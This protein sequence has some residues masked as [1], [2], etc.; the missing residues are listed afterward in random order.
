MMRENTDRNA[1]LADV[2][3]TPDVSGYGFTDFDS[4]EELGRIGYD[5]TVEL[6]DEISRFALDEAEW[7]AYLRA[8]ADRR[9]PFESTPEYFE[10]SGATAVDEP[11]VE[12]ALEHHLGAPLDPDALDFDLTNITGWGRYNVAGYE[13]RKQN[14][15]EGLGVDLHEKTH[16]PPFLRPVLDL[17]GSEF[18]ELFLT[19][20]GRL[21][22][23]DVTGSNSELRID[24][25][26]GQTTRAFAE[27]FARLGNRGL[28]AAP[29]GI[30]S[31]E[32]WYVYDEG[33]TVA[34]YAFDR[35][36]GG[37]DIGYLFG[38]RSELRFGFDVEH[39]KT[40]LKVGDPRLPALEGT[41]GAVT[42][43]WTF[44]G[45]DSPLIVTRGARI[46]AGARWV[47]ATP[48]VV[49]EHVGPLP[50]TDDQF[51]QAQLSTFAARPLAGRFSLFG[52][53][54]GGTSFDA[55]ASQLQRFQLGGPL[56][57]GALRS[58]ELRGS[59]FYLGRAGVLWALSEET[60]PSILGKFYLT[61]FYEVGDAFEQDSDPFWDFTFGLAGESLLGGVFVGGAVGQDGRG[62][63]FFALGRLF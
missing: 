9:R 25:T 22:L 49:G 34:E 41:A 5:A 54:S 44:D 35:V 7:E 62:G 8:R 53:A 29:R 52:S 31:Q 13:G 27:L 63:F 23:F 40:K 43:L 51:Y 56:R 11:V 36:G 20:G 58:G 16:G 15:T 55:T 19:F 42:A 39:Q 3:I 59:H 48:D 28:F 24:A 32:T 26:Y 21:T 33:E 17:R 2:L 61:A 12:A 45:A 37:A 38:P 18:R 30:A 57:L 60:S 46:N 6:A 10:I 4:P 14:D 50:V 1:E 47:F